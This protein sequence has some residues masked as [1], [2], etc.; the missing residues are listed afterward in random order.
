[1]GVKRSTLV[2]LIRQNGEYQ[3]TYDKV[4]EE[5]NKVPKMY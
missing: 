1:M 4:L 3:E 2:V 5:L